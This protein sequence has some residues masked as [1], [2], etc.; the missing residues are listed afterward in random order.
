MCV[1]L[2]VGY[3]ESEAASDD[4][5]SVQVKVKV[6]EMQLNHSFFTLQIL[7]KQIKLQ[8]HH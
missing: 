3:L 6:S 7:Q 2:T 1:D 4:T 5:H 8:K